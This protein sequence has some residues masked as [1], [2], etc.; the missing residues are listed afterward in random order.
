MSSEQ[1]S[2]SELGDQDVTS[3]SVMSEVSS[4]LLEA[5]KQ[6]SQVCLNTISFDQC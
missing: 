3:T 4:F 1:D 2:D 6:A 5:R